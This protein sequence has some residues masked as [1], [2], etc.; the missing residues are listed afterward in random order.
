LLGDPNRIVN[1]VVGGWSLAGLAVLRSGEPVSIQLGSDFNDDGDSTVDRPALI[2]GNLRD[3]Y[4][5]GHLG[6]AQYL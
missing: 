1:I 3:L 4:A 5:R 2:S 6:R